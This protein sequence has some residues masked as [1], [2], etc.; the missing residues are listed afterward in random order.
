MS[1]QF[2]TTNTG[3][4]QPDADLRAV[5]KKSL[6]KRLLA[7][8]ATW[9]FILDVVLIVA[10]GLLSQQQSFW[11]ITNVQ[12]MLLGGTEALLL[13]LGLALL[14]GAGVFDLSLGANLV[15]SSVVGGVTVQ[16]IAGPYSPEGDYNNLAF[17]LVAGFGAAVVTGML[18]GLVNGL[19][20]AYLDIN[21]LIA[22]LGT[23]GIGTGVALVITNGGNVSGLPTE[24]QTNIGLF[25]LGGFLPL[26]TLVAIVL[27]VIVALLL[28]FTRFGMRSLAMGS[29]RTSADRAGIRTRVQIVKLTVLAGAFAGLAGFVDVARFGSTTATGHS[30]D[31]LNA[32]TAVII[33]GTLLEGGR[34]SIIGAIFGTVLAVVLQT[35]L[36]V[37]GVQ[38]F[39]QL[40]AVGV[41][42][43]VAI[44]IDR[45]RFKRQKA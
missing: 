35:G 36:I 25:T 45:F 1:T 42:L 34:V 39:Y 44:S 13:A 14:M 23:M 21:A 33:G 43:I 32:V 2:I 8:T 3:L 30:Q 41:V 24:I 18:F 16:S 37:I 19:I 11:S 27:A 9:V 10:F 5:P 31:A 40:I 22:T 28:R 6:G 26:P 38:P 17:A 12:S 20:I 7:N 29:S 4:L 15:L